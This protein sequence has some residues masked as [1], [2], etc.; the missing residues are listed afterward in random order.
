MKRIILLAAVVASAL[1]LQAQEVSTTQWVQIQKKTAAW[2]SFC[3]TWGWDFKTDMLETYEGQDVLVWSAHFSGDLQNPTA[4]ALS[5]NYGG[6]GQPRFYIDGADLGVSNGNREAKKAEVQD[7]V[8]LNTAFP[9]FYGCGAAAEYDGTTIRV[10]ARAEYFEASGDSPV[11]LGIYLMRK[12]TV[13]PQ[14]TRPDNSVHKNLVVNHFTTEVFGDE[15]SASVQAAGSEFFVEG[16]LELPG[17]DISNYNVVTILWSFTEGQYRFINANVQE[18][19]MSTS[20]SDT[21]LSEAKVTVTYANGYELGV[22]IDSEATM[23]NATFTILN[24]NGQVISTSTSDVS[25]GGYELAL[26]VAAMPTG[27]YI[28][29]LQH[30]GKSISTQFIMQ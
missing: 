20:V 22:K 16:S 5:N 29:N 8:D 4:I 15:I 25:A 21:Y 14:A 17:E 30:E 24:T 7:V 2:C 28:L 9:P 3:G 6:N 11:H 12:E 23:D 19:A 18:I 13:A 27:L 26:P 10:N 1:T